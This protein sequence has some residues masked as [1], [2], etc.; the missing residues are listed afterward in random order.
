MTRRKAI[1][2]LSGALLAAAGL[3]GIASRRSLPPEREALRRELEGIR[4]PAGVATPAPVPDPGLERRI[5]ALEAEV[6]A[7]E[8]KNA[9]LEKRL[10]AAPPP[11][12]VPPGPAEIA[13]WQVTAVD[14]SRSER[15]RVEA[16]LRL[17]LT[18]PDARTPE[19]AASMLLLLGSSPDARV[20]ADICRHLKRAVPL[21]LAAPLLSALAR[22]ADDKVR[23][24][25]AETLGPLHADPSVRA[26][27]EHAAR[28]DPSDKVRLQAARSLQ[29]PPPG[30]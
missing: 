20:R 19:V 17:R 7:V 1:Y 18:G 14:L 22:D 23:E 28:N 12:A 11:A 4:R 26:A 6:A 2:L 21:A 16:L 27:L 8:R 25:A 9:E 10:A 29:E 3:W 24:E 30:R 13:R 5:Q 15:E